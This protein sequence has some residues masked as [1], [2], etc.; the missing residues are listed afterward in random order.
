M[1]RP[2]PAQTAQEA[3]VDRYSNSQWS[4]FGLTRRR[5]HSK[6]VAL[7]GRPEAA[8]GNSLSRICPN[9]RRGTQ[10]GM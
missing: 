1:G 8:P 10:H 3:E 2:L 5:R 7:Q 9:S 6:S 4:P